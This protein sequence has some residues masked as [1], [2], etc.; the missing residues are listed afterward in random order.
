MTSGQKYLSYNINKFDID[1]SNE[2]FNCR[3]F[4]ARV[5]SGGG[6]NLFTEYTKHTVYEIQYALE[7]GMDMLLGEDTQLHIA[8]SDFLIVPPDMYHQIVNA[9][10]QGARFI[11]AFSLNIKKSFLADALSCLAQPKPYHQSPHMRQLLS[12]IL[13]KN[14]HNDA[15]RK[16]SI[17]ALA[18]SFLMEVMEVVSPRKERRVEVPL[19]VPEDQRKV[20]QVEVLLR[21]YNGI[22]LRVS[23]VAHRFGISQRHL[24]RLFTQV[25]GYSLRDAINKEKLKKIEELV[26]TTKLSLTEI[27]QLCGFSDEYAMNKFFR[28]LNNSNLSDF[29]RLGG[30]KEK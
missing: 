20:M 25:R 14:Y 11:M 2:L 22:G 29:R 12:V 15:L 6:E 13:Q 4:W 3:V 1:L 18:E 24:S 10:S 5:V 28:R 7:G 8:E 9:D 17:T 27:S 16:A 21:D 19:S 26:I 23:D 30:N